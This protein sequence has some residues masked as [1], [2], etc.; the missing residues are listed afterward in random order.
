M[1]RNAS[2]KAIFPARARSSG[3]REA[4]SDG[5]RAAENGASYRL[6]H[7]GT[8]RPTGSADTRRREIA[9]LG[10]PMRQLSVGEVGGVALYLVERE[11]RVLKS[12]FKTL[13]QMRLQILLKGCRPNARATWKLSR[14]SP[15][16]PPRGLRR[17]GR[18][19]EIS[20]AYHARYL[21]NPQ[22]VR[23]PSRTFQR[24]STASSTVI[25][26]EQR[27][28]WPA[29]PARSRCRERPRDRRA[30]SR[31]PSKIAA[32]TPANI[33]NRAAARAWHERRAEGE[34][35]VPPPD[36]LT[37]HFARAFITSIACRALRVFSSAV[38]RRLRAAGATA[39]ASPSRGPRRAAARRCRG[40]R[41]HSPCAHLR[42]G[43]GPCART[44]ASCSPAGGI[45]LLGFGR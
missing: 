17:G 13:D 28:R 39:T 27:S 1:R 15:T 12:S 41:E 40:F 38:R 19:G 20:P 29:S 33:Q 42:R 32:T 25:S 37:D 24:C 9:V 4:S 3:G 22:A 36:V 31:P 18:E 44:A 43:H 16:S 34:P 35:H 21:K 26:Y 8:R 6:D 5:L 7:V 11:P 30:R 14:S 10:A 2:P 23:V 45:R